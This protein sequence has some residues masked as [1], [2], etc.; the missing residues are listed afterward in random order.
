MSRDNQRDRAATAIVACNAGSCRSR[1]WPLSVLDGGRVAL[2][3]VGVT[4]LLCADAILLARSAGNYTLLV[5][6]SGEHRVRAPLTFVVDALKTFGLARIHRAAAVNMGQVRR[7]IGRG[8][9]RLCVVLCT[10]MEVDVGR[11]YQRLIR[12]RLGAGT[13]RLPQ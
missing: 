11:G 8:Q 4:E 2:R 13:H 12:T 3:N 10:G 6:E 5:T 7:L 9:H 1:Q